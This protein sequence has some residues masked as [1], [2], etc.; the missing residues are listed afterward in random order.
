MQCCLKDIFFF[1]TSWFLLL[2]N[3]RKQKETSLMYTWK[4]YMITKNIVILPNFSKYLGSK[5]KHN[6][7]NCLVTTKKVSTPV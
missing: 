5:S 2:E 6:D 4:G 1:N 7:K 3:T